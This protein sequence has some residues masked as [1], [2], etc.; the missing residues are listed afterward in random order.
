MNDHMYTVAMELVTERI[1]HHG[2]NESKGL[3]HAADAFKVAADCLK[4]TLTKEQATLFLE[5]ESKFSDLDGGQMR[6]YY[7]AG[8]AD[9]IQFIMGWKEGW[10]GQ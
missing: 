2:A 8:F 10:P 6:S 3:I 9:A 7:E 5:A 1:N 4:V